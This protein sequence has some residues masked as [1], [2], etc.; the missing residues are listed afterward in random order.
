MY[1]QQTYISRPTT[2]ILN[3]WNS[4]FRARNFFHITSLG[5]EF[6]NSRYTG[7]KAVNYTQ[8]ILG[9]GKDYIPAN[10]G[11]MAKLE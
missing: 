7:L 10:L 6:Y 3:S 2:I 8:L 4:I 11:E 9:I 1:W 5:K